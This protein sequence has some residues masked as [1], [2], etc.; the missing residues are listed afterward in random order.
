MTEK[1]FKLY[2]ASAG[3]G[4]TY[5]LVKEFLI[6][7][8]SSDNVS[9]KD[10]L[11]V[12]FTNKAANEMKA[13]ILS[14]LDGFIKNK[15]DKDMKNDL[16]NALNIDETVLVKRANAL[17]DNILHNYSD[18]NISTIDSFIQQVSRSF[19]KELNLPVQ[20][21]VLL[22][23]E[24]LLDGLI[25]NI[26]AQIDVEDKSLTAILGDFI[27]FQLDEEDSLRIDV[28]L[29]KFVKK[30]LKESAYKKGELLGLND[31][32]DNN[33]DYSQIKNVLN[34]SYEKFKT[35][36][37]EDI[38]KIKEFEDEFN[39]VT[40]DYNG[41][42]RGSLQTLM[43]KLDAD[44]NT[45]RSSLM[46]KTIE[47]VFSGD[48]DWYASS[49]L[50]RKKETINDINRSGIDV[51][52][53]YR[54]L[55]EDHKKFFLINIVRK[56]L[57]LYALRRTLLSI[58]KQYIDETNKVHIS[59]FN[60][61]ISDVL[62]DCSVPFIY[63]R[64]GSRYKHF[65][66]D[67]FQDTSLL[68][69]HNF[70]PLVHN[71]L[72]ENNMS[73]LVGDAKQAIYRFRSGEV[74]Q[75]INLPSIYGAEKSG[76][77]NECERKL[78]E[79][80]CRKSLDSNYR[81]KKNIIEFNNS[82]FRLSKYR[83]KSTDYQGVYE[84]LEQKCPK[85][86]P[87]DGYVSVE[88][89]DMDK[90]SKTEQETPLK[91]YKN[92]VKKSI[93]ND[94]NTLID[95][96]FDFRDISILVRGREDGSD[97]AG[98]LSQNDVPVVSSD[99]ILLKSSDKV[100]LVIFTLK[101]ML[102]DK[103]LVDKLTL[104]FYNNICADKSP[105]DIP[106]ALKYD[107]DVN[108]LENIKKKSYSLYDLCSAIITE[109]YGFNIL[110]DEFLQYFLNHVLEWQNSENGGVAAFIEHWDK[111]S[112]DLFVK[113]TSEINAVQ[114]MTIHKSKGLE[115]K[116]VMYP[117]AF[118][119]VPE[120]PKG[121]EKW[122]SSNEFK[123]LNEIPGIDSFILPINK[124]LQGTEMECHYE[125]ELKKAAF[126][127]FNIMYVGMT[128]ASDLMFI[129]T[130]N[131][132]AKSSDKNSDDTYNFFSD[133]FDVENGYLVTTDAG[134]ENVAK[135]EDI[136]F[137]KS[138]VKNTDSDNSVKFELGNIKYEKKSD[139]GEKKCVLELKDNDVPKTLDWTASLIFEADPTMFWAKGH[140]YLPKEWGSLVHEILSKIN[141]SEDV[142]GVLQYYLNE[143]SI[144][145]QHADLL[146]KQFEEIVNTKEIKDA[147]SNDAIVKN[148]M[149]ILVDGDLLV[150][151]K[152]SKTNG[153]KKNSKTGK[154]LRPDRYAELDDKVIL[155]DYKTGE[156]YDSHEVQMKVYA[157]A[158]RQIGV[159]K[160]IEPYLVY[161]KENV[162][163]K[164]EV[165]PVFLD[166]LF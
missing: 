10:I 14:H 71:G 126:D 145:K 150:D 27:D 163:E 1:K 41:G 81:S 56:N 7:S 114:I 137:V 47:S 93:L 159:G 89:F 117:Y 39:I 113:L 80:L 124:N 25:Q 83:L 160:F 28:S 70:L 106:E 76:F 5:T 69:W 49:A 166:T 57:Y 164:I 22:D 143:G 115:F 79:H 100:R 134:V 68:Q 52:G 99:S 154:I 34:E 138:F 63:E 74:E 95:N 18:F 165:K 67:E 104:S 77:Y 135:Q 110:E 155:I 162:D 48:K 72:S 44:I 30:L 116:V 88:M 20:Y 16:L 119:K 45:S 3:S 98:Y 111:K 75:I 146:K 132:K 102:D 142:D 32:F 149:D 37:L 2:T 51:V 21:R 107:V 151:N 133:Y 13:K 90:F 33:Y 54:K 46:K 59:E 26:D 148:E 36:V 50:K 78:T 118:A 40:E 91:L 140:D 64:I 147:Y 109:M 94:I 53:L 123:L 156:Y 11:A 161:L 130:H 9:C 125:E 58:V 129:Y 24:M 108:K 112:N 17:Y 96:G 82:F 4:K 29:R 153:E 139:A 43:T 85:E 8:M 86:R 61:R 120:A 19:S 127:D 122:M 12:T 65:F 136:D 141:T 6:L 35:V 152:A 92:A 62:G 128:R 131:T 87:Y 38:A 66:I 31:D 42:S 23:D 60:K 121:S 103:N 97:I 157:E 105:Y 158:L 144:D 84:G 55:N 101:Y 15:G 73:L